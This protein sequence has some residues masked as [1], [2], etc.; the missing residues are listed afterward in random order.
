MS[1]VDNRSTPTLQIQPVA[2]LKTRR[3][4][5]SGRG[6]LQRLRFSLCPACIFA[7]LPGLDALGRCQET[8][9]GSG[10]SAAEM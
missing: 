2:S 5:E 8:V 9:F 6:V 7:R 4:N 10:G 1:V 3:G